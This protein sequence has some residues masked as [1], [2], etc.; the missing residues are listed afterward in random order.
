MTTPTVP[1]ERAE[2]SVSLL[3]F[4]L[5]AHQR[6]EVF[7]SSDAP[8]RLADGAPDTIQLERQATYIRLVSIAENFCASLL[9]DTVEEAINPPSTGPLSEI[10]ESAVIGATGSWDKQAEKFNSWLG[11]K[12]SLADIRAAAEVRNAIAH[13]LGSLTRLQLR[14][15]Q[16]TRN[17]ISQTA[18][19]ELNGNEIHLTTDDLERARTICRET[20]EQVDSAVAARDQ[21]FRDAKA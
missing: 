11:V 18:G 19:V 3:N 8:E 15:E 10:W 20:I 5:A 4:T 16:S 21:R 7:L 9:I 14:N 2:Q 13:G 6:V 17:K 12:P 1:S